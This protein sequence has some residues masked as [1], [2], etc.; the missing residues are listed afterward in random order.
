MSKILKRIGGVLLS[1]LLASI[2]LLAKPADA[3]SL[4]LEDIAASSS[5]VID[6]CLNTGGAF[7]FVF[8]PA[9]NMFADVIDYFLSQMDSGFN[10]DYLVS[11]GDMGD[12]VISVWSQILPV[13]NVLFAV[14][15]LFVVYSVATGQ[16]INNYSVKKIMPRLVLIAIAVNV[17]YYICAALIDISNIVGTSIYD[18]V[19][20]TL[21]SNSMTATSFSNLADSVFQN[22]G[23]SLGVASGT[24]GALLLL[25]STFAIVILAIGAVFIC[26]AARNVVLMLLLLLS[27]LAFSMALLPNTENLFRRWGNNFLRLIAIYPAFMFVWAICRGL[28]AAFINYD[29]DTLQ[30]TL[31]M[32]L[33]VA[34]VVV[35]APLFKG[36][37]GLTGKVANMVQRGSVGLSSTSVVGGQAVGRKISSQTIDQINQKKFTANKTMT[38][39]ANNNNTQNNF[40]DETNSTLNSRTTLA[41]NELRASASD[42][43]ANLKSKRA[44]TLSANLK[45]K[46]EV[47]NVQVP[48]SSLQDSI[49]SGRSTS[50]TTSTNINS[51]NSAVSR[52][53]SSASN[54]NSLSNSSQTSNIQN[55]AIA[56]ASAPR[57]DLNGEF[58]KLADVVKAKNSAQNFTRER[59]NS[60]D[61]KPT[62]T[63]RRQTFADSPVADNKRQK[64]FDISTKDPINNIFSGEGQQVSIENSGGTSQ[65]IENQVLDNPVAI[66]GGV[67]SA[68][69]TDETEP[70]IAEDEINGNEINQLAE[71]I[72]NQNSVQPSDD[73]VAA[74]PSI[75]D[76]VISDDDRQQRFAG[77]EGQ[78]ELAK[79]LTVTN[80]KQ[81]APSDISYIL[82]IGPLL[83]KQGKE[84]APVGDISKEPEYK[85]AAEIVS[86]YISTLS[87]DQKQATDALKWQKKLG[88]L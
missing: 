8:C 64:S 26:I 65:L 23:G 58:D 9:V 72:R 73:T 66:D 35:V 83:D 10:W 88:L 70:T 61:K 37:G 85:A 14:V 63:P 43:A 27:P 52:Q 57:L 1:V 32:L 6:P 78:K 31:A 62:P 36:M 39:N 60:T 22:S 34:P 30:L 38:T 2:F 40:S 71:N 44:R 33:S 74:A 4:G 55:S 29:A 18:L 76:D 50:T 41:A 79:M 19:Y 81:F 15:F 46:V 68:V 51:R 75:V 77:K 47:S 20:N 16:G 7:G 84:L 13:A 87:D 28:Q 49:N 82:G 17:S 12:S 56:A 11:S 42:S 67:P 53:T 54:L 48:G 3:S 45:S 86:G 59:A 80:I 5:T 24:I 21:N 69:P 25:V